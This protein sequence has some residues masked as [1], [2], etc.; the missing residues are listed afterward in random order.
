MKHN[1]KKLYIRNLNANVTKDDM[2]ELFV[3]KS[4]R[5][6][7]LKAP[8]QVSEYLIKLNGFEFQKQ[9]IWT[10][11][12]RTSRQTWH[13]NR[14]STNHQNARTSSVINR[15]SS[16]QH[17]F[18]KKVTPGEKEY[19]ET[20]SSSVTSLSP[21]FNESIFPTIYVVIFGDSLVNLNRKIKHDTNRNLNNWSTRFKYFPGVTSK[22]LLHYVDTTL[23]DNSFEVAVIYLGIN[24]IV[25]IKNSLNT[26][27][28]LQKCKEYCWEVQE[29][30]HTES[31]N[32]GVIYH[33]SFRARFYRR[34]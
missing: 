27:H 6:A 28:I 24:D 22:D 34:S 26:D 32:F 12:A 33:T 8:Q 23:Q 10:E 11:N 5:F 25:N 29:L 20:M 2:N 30:W 17:L 15:D 4:K 18:N 21:T 1:S 14:F 13:Y 31:I 19:A 7:F 9:S 3:L 16:N